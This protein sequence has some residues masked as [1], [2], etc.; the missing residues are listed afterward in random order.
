MSAEASYGPPDV[1]LVLH[2]A[3]SG[4]AMSSNNHDHIDGLEKPS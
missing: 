4:S 1:A 2:A 3:S